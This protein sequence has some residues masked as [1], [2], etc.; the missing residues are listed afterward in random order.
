MPRL[1]QIA[2][3]AK[4]HCALLVN[5]RCFYPFVLRCAENTVID[6][7]SRLKTLTLELRIHDLDALWSA[8]MELL[9]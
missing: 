2:V 9:G 7:L 1:Q 3:T 4:L 6:E 8:V 5:R